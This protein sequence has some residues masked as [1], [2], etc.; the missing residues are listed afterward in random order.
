M[1]VLA[2]AVLGLWRY[3]VQRRQRRTLVWALAAAIG[4]ME[5]AIRWQQT[6]MM[7]LLEGLAARETVGQYFH[8]TADMVQGG[9]PLQCAWEKAF[10]AIPDGEAGEILARLRLGGAPP[11]L[12]R[13][14]GPTRP[15]LEALYRRRC[16]E[17][18]QR[19][20]VTTAAALCGAG[21][22]IILLI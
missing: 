11:R 8:E 10:S 21:L 1:L 3:G 9:M 7:A 20:R 18:G 16:R 12:A 13:A 14:P 17:D 15:A 5:S 6:P 4:E 19:S 2:A 22:V